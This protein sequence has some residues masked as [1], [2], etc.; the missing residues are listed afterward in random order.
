MK[1]SLFLGLIWISCFLALALM[2]FNVEA[3]PGSHNIATS[4]TVQIT[5]LIGTSDQHISSI[6]TSPNRLF[7][8]NARYQSFKEDSQK[9]GIKSV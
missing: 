4:K 1:Y 6:F 2:S 3:H 9:I 7:N 5:L 8:Q